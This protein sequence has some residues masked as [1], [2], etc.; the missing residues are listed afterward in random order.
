MARIVIKFYGLIAWVHERSDEYPDKVLALLADAAYAGDVEKLPSYVFPPK[1]RKEERSE[2]P[3][4]FSFLKIADNAR[5]I[6][7]LGKSV[8]HIGVKRLPIAYK[9]LEFLHDGPEPI[10]RVQ[11]FENLARLGP[12]RFNSNMKCK[13]LDKYTEWGSK[14]GLLGDHRVS[15]R[16]LVNSGL[17]QGAESDLNP[18]RYR[19]KNPEGKYDDTEARP[20]VEQVTLTFEGATSLDIK[21]TDSRKEG[22]S[23]TL[24]IKPI[25]SKKSAII[26]IVNQMGAT[27]FGGD[28]DTDDHRHDQVF[29]WFY[30]LIDH[31]FWRK[32]NYFPEDVE[33]TSEK[34]SLAGTRCPQ[35]GIDP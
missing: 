3:A 28:K 8:T 4:H 14:P 20:L 2:F 34:D 25:N 1:T 35:G 33:E 23:D 30:H 24:T 13:V 6:Q 5:A 32:N 15:A 27:V 17:L 16:V 19:F 29:R 11:G 31:K 7:K 12:D 9:D 18:R 26:K 21:M 10:L 22:Y